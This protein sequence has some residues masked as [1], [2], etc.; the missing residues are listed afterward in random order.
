MKD[1]LP[2]FGLAYIKVEGAPIHPDEIMDTD[3][4]P[5]QFEKWYDRQLKA[6]NDWFAKWNPDYR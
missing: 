4:T 6:Y 5:E 2:N 3:M 1:D